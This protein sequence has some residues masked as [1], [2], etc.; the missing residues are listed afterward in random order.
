MFSKDWVPYLALLEVSISAI[1]SKNV[2]VMIVKINFEMSAPADS[3][4]ISP[5][6]FVG[7][8]VTAA[9]MTTEYN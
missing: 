2:L 6:L 9:L 1:S 8:C 5:F 3:A 7:F 4:N